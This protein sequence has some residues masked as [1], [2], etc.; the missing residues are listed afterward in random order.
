[1][2]LPPRKRRATPAR[3][4]ARAVAEPVEEAP[5]SL[6]PATAAE[7]FAAVVAESP[8]RSLEDRLADEWMPGGED[9]VPTPVLLRMQ[10]FAGH[11]LET[12]NGAESARRAG[13]APAHADKRA[14]MLLS[15]PR[16]LSMI[17]EQHQSLLAKIGVS[18]ER[19]WAEYARIA[20]L[21]PAELFSESG[22]LKKMH[23]VP[24]DVRRAIAGMKITHKTFG[25]DGESI[26]REIK[27][28]NKS[29]ALEKLG[30]LT[31]MF[32]EEKA[33]TATD[34]ANAIIEGIAHARRRVIEGVTPDAGA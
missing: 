30:R 29:D 3:P 1:M 33:A 12:L 7:H 4:V 21:D 23:D 18:Q 28:V 32:R 11:Y 6:V 19:I 22:D 9:W 5:R 31:G 27:F 20:F 34:I 25:D 17:R 26:E 14:R 15:H 13:Y 8:E 16:V 2:A 24:E 10:R